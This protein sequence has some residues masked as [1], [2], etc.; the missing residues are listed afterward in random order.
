M[1]NGEFAQI[2]TLHHNLLMSRLQLRITQRDQ[3]SERIGR[4]REQINGLV[5]MRNATDQET[6]IFKAE[7]EALEALREKRVINLAL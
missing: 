5:R 6:H 4:L 1:R 7:A 2:I 3:L